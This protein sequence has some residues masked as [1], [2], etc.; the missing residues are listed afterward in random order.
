MKILD[1]DVANIGDLAYVYNAQ[2]AARVPHCYAVSPEVLRKGVY[3]KT[4]PGHTV[5]QRAERVIVAEC[6]GQVRGF[7]H[8]ALGEM[9]WG[10]SE[11]KQSGGFI[12]FLTYEPGYRDVGQAL[13]AASER[14]LQSE[15]RCS[16][17]AFDGYLYRFHHFGFPLI[18]DRMMHIYGLF[19]INGYTFAHD[20][21]IFLAQP[22]PEISVPVSPDRSVEIV[23]RRESGQGNLPNV[24]TLAQRDGQE[25]GGCRTVSGGDYCRATAAQDCIFVDGLG[26]DDAEQGKG[27]GRYLLLRTLSEAQQLGYTRTVISTSKNN[28]R[29]QLFYTNYGYRVTDTVYNFVKHVASED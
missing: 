18:S 17:W 7:A 6:D 16:I 13:L 23:V 10:Q 5:L 14:H 28:Y 25:I 21:E 9:G 24:V 20:G 8:I 11:Q 19:G 3:E 12:H 26:V 27:W 29:A 1:W 4:D 15:G 22:L 2:I